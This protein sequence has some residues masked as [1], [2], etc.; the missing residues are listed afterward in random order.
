MTMAT[1]EEILERQYSFI[2]EA[3]PDDGGWVVTF[4]DLPGCITQGD[5]F[6]EVAEMAEDAFRLWITAQHENGFPIPEP[7]S[8]LS[9]EWDWDKVKVAPDVPMFT[10]PN[11]AVQLGV[12]PQRV[13]QLAKSRGVGSKQ[14]G[15][16]LFSH[17]D[18]KAMTPRKSGRPKGLPEV[19]ERELVKT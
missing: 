11:A 15:T 13:Y 9:S 7:G 16:I 4:P 8:H 5:T 14:G 10:V 1:L 18:V 19:R 12:S 17:D 2:A 3:D 6:Q